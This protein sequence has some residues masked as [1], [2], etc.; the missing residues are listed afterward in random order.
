MAK[1]RATGSNSTENGIGGMVRFLMATRSLIDNYL[2]VDSR[3]I[4]AEALM[5]RALASGDVDTIA[6]ALR[7]AR[8]EGTPEWRRWHDTWLREVLRS[9]SADRSASDLR[10]VDRDM[11][12]V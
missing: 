7:L 8:I 2:P 10:P 9:L 6:E 1:R 4:E 11:P 5:R 12:Q 3:Q